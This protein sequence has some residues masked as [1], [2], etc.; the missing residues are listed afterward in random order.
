MLYGIL[1]PIIRLSLAVF[2]KKISVIGSDNLPKD[3]P[4][5]FVANHPSAVIDP[6]VVAITLK[7]KVYFLAGAEWFGKG[8]KARVFKKQLNMIPVHRPW[9]AKDEKVSNVDMF[10]DCYESLAKGKWIIIFPE[11]SSVTVSKIRELKT[12]AIRIKKGFEEYTNHQQSVPIIPVG[13]SYTNPHK[14]QS[15][16]Y[17]KI[18]EPIKFEKT[19]QVNDEKAEVRDL[20]NQMFDAL[21]ET[22]IHIDND[23]NAPI[24]KKVSHLF[25]ETVRENANVASSEV[26]PNFKFAQDIAKAVDYFQKEEPE[27]F[28]KLNS[29]IDSYLNSVKG[30][31]LSDE[32]IDKKSRSNS[33]LIFIFLLLTAPLFLVSVVLFFVPYQLTKVIFLKKLNP[34]I[35]DDYESDG[36][37]PSFTGSLIF[38]MGMAVFISWMLFWGIVFGLVFQSI[39]IAICIIIIG[40]P[41]FNFSLF[42]SS[43]AIKWYRNFKIKRMRKRHASSIAQLQEVRQG[44]INELRAYQLKFNELFL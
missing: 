19:L 4:A 35:D 31:G 42:Y 14:F 37:N 1:K 3:G 6:L 5:I 32:M 44:I 34:L 7:R 43:F 27:N 28:S 2:F 39:L 8:L 10:K 12:G 33:V 9:L 23:E 24:V 30:Y 11:A 13:L 41:L 25:L 29:R 18:G 15:S 38:I 22:V 21:K 40:H 36:L 20:A 17:V 26:E 16:L